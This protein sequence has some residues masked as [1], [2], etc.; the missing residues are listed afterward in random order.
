M[1][2]FFEEIF[3]QILALFI[4][5]MALLKEKPKTRWKTKDNLILRL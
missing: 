5:K 2:I 4:L 3:K 1:E